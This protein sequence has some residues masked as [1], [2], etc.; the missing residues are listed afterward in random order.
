MVASL[1]LLIQTRG[2][3]LSSIINALLLSQYTTPSYQL[4]TQFASPPPHPPSTIAP[5]LLVLTI[6]PSSS[7]ASTH[8]TIT[9]NPCAKPRH[10]PKTI[11]PPCSLIR[12]WSTLT[13]SDLTGSLPDAA[14]SHS[15][16]LVTRSSTLE[17]WYLAKVGSFELDFQTV[18]SA[19]DDLS[20]S[21]L[22]A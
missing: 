19:S 13:P 20:G 22:R 11:P 2:P 17:A 9:P 5:L 6:T 1:F 16:R 14:S 21:Y 10:Q 4:P 8:K 18:R 3:T 7:D 12:H 15:P